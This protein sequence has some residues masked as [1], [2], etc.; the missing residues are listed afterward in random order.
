MVFFIIFVHV[1]IYLHV[2]VYTD[3][4]RMFKSY[5]SNHCL[6]SKRSIFIKWGK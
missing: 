6:E 5:M 2:N 3:I 1:F 4:V